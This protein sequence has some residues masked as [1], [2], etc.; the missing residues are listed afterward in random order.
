[1]LELKIDMFFIAILYTINWLFTAKWPKNSS[2]LK[3]MLSEI[4]DRPTSKHYYY[5]VQ[6]CH[7]FLHA[8]T[9]ETKHS[10]C[11]VKWIKVNY[12]G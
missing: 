3:I 7:I 6:C 4:N 12:S 5:S 1:M 2:P 11:I 8:F 9:M 10:F